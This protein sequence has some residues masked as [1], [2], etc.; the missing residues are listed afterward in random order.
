MDGKH[1]EDSREPPG[2]LGV[3]DSSSTPHVAP[4]ISS[5]FISI[6]VVHG[7]GDPTPIMV[8]VETTQGA[9]YT[10][11]LVGV[12]STMVPPSLVLELDCSRGSNCPSDSFIA[13]NVLSKGKVAGISFKVEDFVEESRLVALEA[14]DGAAKAATGDIK[15]VP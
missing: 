13:K 14:R 9:C 4:C 12:P 8:G 6:V 11:Q 7:E 10:T 15:G 1:R 5:H 3:M 2:R